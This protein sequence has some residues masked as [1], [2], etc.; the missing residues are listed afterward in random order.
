VGKR[1]HAATDKRI[2]E[3]NS[4]TYHPKPKWKQINIPS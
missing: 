2:F 4:P 3:A 1:R